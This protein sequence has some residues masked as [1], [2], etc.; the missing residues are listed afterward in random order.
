ME[1][2]RVSCWCSRISTTSAMNCGQSVYINCEEPCSLRL[3]S[4]YRLDKQ[5]GEFTLSSLESGEILCGNPVENPDWT[6]SM[7]MEFA[8]Y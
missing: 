3:L 6:L 1:A 2:D 8:V 4:V 5:C 7:E